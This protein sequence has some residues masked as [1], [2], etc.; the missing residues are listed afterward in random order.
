M[1]EVASQITSLTI[2]YSTVYSDADQRKHQSFASLAFVWGIHRRPVN[3]PHKWPVTRKMF[4][5][6]DVIVMYVCPNLQWVAENTWQGARVIAPAKAAG[7]FVLLPLRFALSRHIELFL[8]LLL[9]KGFSFFSDQL[10]KIQ[11]FHLMYLFIIF[12][13][14]LFLHHSFD[15][16]LQAMC[17]RNNRWIPWQWAS[18]AESLLV[19]VLSTNYFF[20]NKPYFFLH[21]VYFSLNHTLTT[22]WHGLLSGRIHTKTKSAI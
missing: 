1:G 5:F 22:Y 3:S 20:L 16:A 12:L 8:F 15:F 4:P 21:R 14:V 2:V 19:P 9:L 11:S 7:W 10:L 13:N 17:K 18:N 6:D